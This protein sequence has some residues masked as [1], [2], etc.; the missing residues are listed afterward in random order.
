M[1]KY[2]LLLIMTFCISSG[3]AAT[4]AYEGFDYSAGSI[5]GESGGN[6]WG[7]S[8]SF[9][10]TQGT[11]EIVASGL[12]F[13]DFPVA[14]GAL[15]LTE[16]N[17]AGSYR[18]VGV[19]REVD[20]DTPVGADLWISFL[21]K[22]S[23]PITS[24]TSKTAEIRH[25][26]TAGTT[27]LRMRPKG[28]GSQGVMIAYDSSANNSAAKSTQDGNTY[29]YVCRFGD[30]GTDSGKYA[31]MWVFDE[32]GYNGAM[33]DGMLDEEDLNNNYYIMAQDTHANR[34]L[35]S[36][37]GALINIGDSSTDQFSYYFDELRYGLS[38]QDVIP[39]SLL[40]SNPSPAWGAEGVRPDAVLEWQPGSNVVSN[41]HE[42]Y[43][44][45]DRDAVEA[46][47]NTDTTGIFLGSQDANS[48]SPG[49][50]ELAERY[51]WRV[52]Q[53]STGGVNTGYVWDFWTIASVEIDSFDAY[54]DTTD[55]K[56]LW[57]DYVQNDSGA[58]IELTTE[59]AYNGSKSMKY[60]YESQYGDSVATKVYAEY[61]DWSVNSKL[62]V[63]DIVFKG[64]ASNSTDE[65]LYVSVKDS[66][67]NSTTVNYPDSFA[68]AVDQW[69]VWNIEIS[70]F[71]GV[72]FENVA[73]FTIGFTGGASGSG[74]VYFDGMAIYPC[75]A[76]SL[77]SDINEDCE[78]NMEDFAI[79]AS[80]WMDIALY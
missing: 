34:M 71:S 31:V 27:E 50:L 60:L 14:G 22:S 59:A 43:F 28:S 77:S 70:E 76:G 6:G 25:G 51:F 56:I 64:A 36:N 74:E 24:F 58:T 15:L 37:D 9:T 63:M 16:D 57:Q 8:W 17:T 67:G 65:T 40:A 10:Y 5:V 35:D 62:L 49:E 48:L 38:L 4:L 75:R 20:F 47:D 54:T 18:S 32:A 78:V 55:M 46:A 39:N 45:T 44:G 2:L 41:G 12:T 13:S 1:K 68:L 73:E 7:G 52:D 61:Q 26:P 80:Q 33:S 53:V 30:M 19:R 21:A 29:L 23:E 79:M 11:E 42:I 69:T 72:D 3:Y 66:A